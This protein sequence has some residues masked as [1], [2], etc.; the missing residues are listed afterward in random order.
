[1]PML[2]VRLKGDWNARLEPTTTRPT[3]TRVRTRTVH[4]DRKVYLKPTCCCC[5]TRIPPR[6]HSSI[7]SECVCRSCLAQAPSHVGPY[8]KAP[9][10]PLRECH[11]L[12]RLARWPPMASIRSRDASALV[13]RPLSGLCA[14]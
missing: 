9:E 14:L 3:V 5:C 2:L 6:F 7:A 4:L 1:M 12:E 10:T 8:A 11:S 13:L